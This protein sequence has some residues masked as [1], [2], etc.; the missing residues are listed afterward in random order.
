MWMNANEKDT[1]EREKERERVEGA[2]AER[3]TYRKNNGGK[4]VRSKSQ[5]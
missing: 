4:I 5:S 3:D 1:F 2:H